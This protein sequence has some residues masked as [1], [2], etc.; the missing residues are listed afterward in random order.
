[1]GIV[2][3]PFEYYVVL[4]FEATCDR[5]KAPVP[6]EIIEFPSVLLSGDTFEI[7]DEFRSFVQPRFNRLLTPFCTELTGITQDQV[8]QA[9]LFPE[10]LDDHIAWLRGRGLGVRSRDEGS[11]FAYITCG[12]WDLQKM[13]RTQ[14]R[15]CQP[16]I[17]RIPEAFE[18]W[19]NIKKHFAASFGL[20][21][22]SGMSGMLRRLKLELTGRHH[23]GID[24]CRNIAK[25]VRCLA[26]RGVELSTT[27]QP[28]GGP[29]GL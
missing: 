2:K 18:R 11:D 5:G 20:K 22:T 9:P 28:P 27:N 1:M 4:D 23:C 25:I 26:G 14:C 7:L 15:V 8:D 21:K 3:Q 19:V 24:D 12:D 29:G 6:Q 10:V 17:G 13:F 16:P